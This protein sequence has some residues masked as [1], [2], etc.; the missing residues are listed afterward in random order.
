VVDFRARAKIPVVTARLGG[1][2][3]FGGGVEA[4]GDRWLTFLNPDFGTLLLVGTIHLPLFHVVIVEVDHADNSLQMAAK[5]V[6]RVG[7]SVRMRANML[8]TVVISNLRLDV[9]RSMRNRIALGRLQGV[10]HGK[11]GVYGGQGLQGTWEFF[12]VGK[13]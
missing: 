3:C 10:L 11:R 9:H 13:R 4:N 6:G 5:A 8:S 7:V 12:V 1:L 2:G